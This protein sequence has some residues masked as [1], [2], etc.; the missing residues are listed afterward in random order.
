MAITDIFKKD[1][2]VKPK[3]VTSTNRGR[4]PEANSSVFRPLFTHSFNG[5]KNLGEI[6]PIKSY[7]PSYGE[8]SMRSWQAYIESAEAQTVINK[9]I[10]WVLGSGL[11]MQSEPVKSVLS[12]Y[13]IKVDQKFNETVEGLWK[14]Y[15]GSK[16]CDYS[17]MRNLGKI[18]KRALKAAKNG[19]DILVVLHYVKGEVKVQ[20]ID[21]QHI[22]APQFGSEYAPQLQGD[23]NFLKNGIV[24][25]PEGEHLG[26]WVKTWQMKYEF[27]PA[28][29]AET[30]LTTAYLVYGS[31]Y[32]TDSVRGM[33]LL[34][35]LLERLKKL[36]RYTE[37]TVGSAEERQKIPYFFEHDIEST[38][39]NPMISSMVKATNYQE[40]KNDNLPVD[41]HGQ[42]LA[43]KVA[44]T[45]NKQVF[46]MPQG[47]KI[48][49]LETKNDLTFEPFHS[50][51]FNIICSA[52][53]IPPDVARSLYNSN[54]S[55]SRAAVKDWE[56]TLHVEREDFS[57]QFYQPL[58]QFWFHV[59]VLQNKI[60]AP[61]YLQ[62]FIQ[63]NETVI[64][65][66]TTCRFVGPPVPHIDPLK[67]VE[68][69]RLKLGDTGAS[70][71]LTTVEAATES[72]NSGD[73]DENIAQYAEEL[74][75]V[76]KLGIK[77]EPVVTQ[78]V[79][80]KG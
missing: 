18:A 31:E 56:H 5:E 24:M 61:G 49:F 68:A 29:S 44:A 74:A 67:E 27:I 48:K 38:G 52:I 37:A 2:W 79:P 11:K 46:N 30:G 32:R 69:A 80:V 22:V 71:P 33:P 23:G 42:Q 16:S 50:V 9:F 20:L 62:A 41:V 34:S 65:S 7:A 78:S 47:A 15:A 77:V 21:G 64:N 25:T 45:T 43:D 40:E 66:Y 3:E 28:K 75:E 39:Q 17:N 14:V 54:Y 26:Y 59:K 55:A 10:V 6:G 53:G 4:Q 57:S 8:L 72:L 51:L 63:D 35:V 13:G 58:F 19:G 1:F 70:I 12:N 76:K 60:Q 73:S 36:D